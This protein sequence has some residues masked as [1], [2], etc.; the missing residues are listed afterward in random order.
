MALLFPLPDEPTTEM[1]A[2]YEVLRAADRYP[3]PAGQA[4]FWAVLSGYSEDPVAWVTRIAQLT[5]TLIEDES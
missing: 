1:H 3:V 4:A 2:A 5:S